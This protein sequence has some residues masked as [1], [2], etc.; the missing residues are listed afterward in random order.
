MKNII[1]KFMMAIVG[2]ALFI[3]WVA[4]LL[5]RVRDHI[6]LVFVSTLVLTALYLFLIV[7]YQN[8][9]ERSVRYYKV[10][11]MDV[12]IYMSTDDPYTDKELKIFVNAIWKNC[13]WEELSYNDYPEERDNYLESIASNDN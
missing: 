5:D 2:M 10:F 8:N 11:Y 4:I 12:W 7:R 6:L 13:K 9:P 1:I 3:L